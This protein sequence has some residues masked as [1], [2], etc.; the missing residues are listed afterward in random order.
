MARNKH[1]EETV[2]LILD[3]SFRLFLE[4]GYEHTSIQNIIDHLGGLSK[5]AIYHH[6]ASKE[7]ILIAVIDR[8]TADS[9]QLLADIRDRTDLTG[10]EKLKTIF[11]ASIVRPVQDDLFTVAPDLGNNPRFLSC[12][13]LDTINEVAPNYI[14]PIIRQGQEDGTITTDYPAELAELIILAA[15]IWMNPMIFH[16][17][18]QVAYN[19]FRVF[20]QMMKGFGLDIMDQEM[21]DRLYQLAQIYEK[22][23]D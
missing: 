2:N 20:D 7:D 23:Q 18:A 12:I 8:I 4:K 13:F 17:S 16:N 15:N 1:P 9:N 11:K 3:V 22:H 6:F 21:L 10:K 5:G 19:K 14:L